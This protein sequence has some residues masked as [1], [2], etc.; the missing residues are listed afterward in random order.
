[1]KATT[2]S[3]ADLPAAGTRKEGIVEA[4]KNRENGQSGVQRRQQRLVR[5]PVTPLYLLLTPSQVWSI[6]SSCQAQDESIRARQ[7]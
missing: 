7:A 2:P 6:C 1:M 5:D 3:P 4:G